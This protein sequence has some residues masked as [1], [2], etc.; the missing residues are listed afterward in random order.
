MAQKTIQIADKPT[1]NETKALLENSGYGLE[2]IKNAISS[3]AGSGDSSSSVSALQIRK[4]VDEQVSG[5]VSVSTLPYDFCN[6]SAVVLN[7]EIHI[8][9]GYSSGNYKKHYKYNGSSWEEVSTL[10]YNFCYGSAVV[11]NNEIHILGGSDSSSTYTQHY[12]YNGSSWSS[13]S[14]LP[15]GFFRGSAVVLNNEIHILGSNYYKSNGSTD[16]TKRP[17]RKNHYKYNGSSWESVSTLPYAFCSGCAVVLNNEIHILGSEYSSRTEH[18]KF[19]GSS[20][21]SISTLPYAFYDGSAVVYN[22]EIHILG[23]GGSYSDMTNHYKFNGSSWESLS[24]LPYR[25]GDGAA[26]VWNDE[27][28]I[29]G[30]YSNNSSGIGNFTKHYNVIPDHRRILTLLPK[31][32]HILLPNTQNIIYTSDKIGEF[33]ESVEIGRKKQI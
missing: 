31:E 29:L 3:S 21:E 12:K 6:G 30:S 22:N 24:T 5:C 4:I 8:L 13:V 32:T 20:W 16:D 26:V 33:Y 2:A 19:N 18:Y 11:W 27:I 7:G 14:T 10:P 15:Y 9:G 23:G 17:Y 28:H 1:L 25:F